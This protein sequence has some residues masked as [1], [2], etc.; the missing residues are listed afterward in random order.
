M[1][2]LRTKALLVL[3]QNNQKLSPSLNSV[4]AHDRNSLLQNDTAPPSFKSPMRAVKL[5]NNARF[6][7][8]TSQN[9]PS[10]LNFHNTK[11]SS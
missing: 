7:I 6:Y 9:T 8:F 4:P 1:L 10:N 2:W 5:K 11:I 3:Q